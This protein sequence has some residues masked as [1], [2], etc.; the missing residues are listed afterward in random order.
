MDFGILQGLNFEDICNHQGIIE[1]FKCRL[2]KKLKNAIMH[3]W[4]LD[5]AIR[6]EIYKQPLFISCVGK[7]NRGVPQGLDSNFQPASPLGNCLLS[8]FFLMYNY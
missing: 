2:I 8:F 7:Y 5:Q 6:R 4:Y 1:V 3:L